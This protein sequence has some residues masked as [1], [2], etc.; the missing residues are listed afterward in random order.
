MLII[1][2]KLNSSI[3]RTLEAVSRRDTACLSALIKQQ[4]ECGADIL[5]INTALCTSELD[6][7]L[8]LAALVCEHSPCGIMFDS[9]NPGVL[10]RCVAQSWDRR[11]M[12]NSLTL[13]PEYD[14]LIGAL[15][16]RDV[17]V[18]CLPMEAASLPKT[19]DERFAIAKKI[20]VRL[21]AAGI[22]PENI[23]IDILVEAIASAEH[24]AIPALQ[25]LKRLK[26]GTGVKTIC[27]L[28]NVSF[29]LPARAHLNGA[30]LAMAMQQGLDGAIMDITSEHMRSTLAAA[31]ALLGNDEFCLDYITQYKARR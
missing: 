17:G 20:I 15:S 24:A 28:S 7:M 6:D 3:P 31:N 10:A 2:E 22:A 1:G 19:V 25:T 21:N 16:K 9:P 13:A 23:Y 4:A 8:W 29:G 14:E 26:D 18:V 12:V 11:I 5:D 27:G 30:F